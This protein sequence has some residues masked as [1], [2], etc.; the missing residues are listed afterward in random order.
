MGGRRGLDG[1]TFSYRTLVVRT[2]IEKRFITTI[3]L[4]IANFTGPFRVIETTT[5][6][7][8]NGI[9]SGAHDRLHPDGQTGRDGE[10]ALLGGARPCRPRGVPQSGV[11]AEPRRFIAEDSQWQ[12]RRR[13]A[14]P[15]GQFHRA[16]HVLLLL[17]LG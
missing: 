17:L 8:I 7:E 2:N 9:Q 16:R 11:G 1:C 15:K 4:N 10:V 12:P 14:V 3:S 6:M 13:R 5:H